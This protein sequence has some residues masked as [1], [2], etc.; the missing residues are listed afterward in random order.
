M[1]TVETDR[2]EFAH[3]EVDADPHS[4]PGLRREMRRCLTPL[5]LGSDRREE[6][7]L[8]VD[9]AAANA[10]EHAYDPGEPGTVE[11]T[12]WTETN[13]LCVEVSDHG[14][15]REPGLTSPGFAGRGRGITLMSRLIDCVL[16]HHDARGTRVLLRHP[17]NQPAP[18]RYPP[19]AFPTPRAHHLPEVAR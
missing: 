4:L 5:S 14:H 7:V 3:L 2:T 8:A 6:V 9:E 12:F 19:V 18:D 16:I 13:A 17:I 10:V 15:W 1:R 11:L